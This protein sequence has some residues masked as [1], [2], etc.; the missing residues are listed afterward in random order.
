VFT[1]NPSSFVRPAPAV[2]LLSF[3]VLGAC[4]GGDAPPVTESP[5]G[6]PW[7]G[8][9]EPC[10]EK[11]DVASTGFGRCAAHFLPAESTVEAGGYGH[12]D[13]HALVS[14]PPLGST[15]VVSL[16]CGGSI[17]VDLGP[18][19]AVDGPG[20]DFV[21][22]EN[23]FSVEFPEVGHV[24]VSEDG[25]EWRKFPC[26]A[27]EALDGCAGRTPTSAVWA[28]D[29][30]DWEPLAA[31]GDPFDLA[32][33]GLE[34]A[35]FVRVVDESAAFWSGLDGDWCDPGMGGKGGFDLDAIAVVNEG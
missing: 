28:P 17:V 13:V 33:L 27:Q 18:E 2:C 5:P 24:W 22:F 12:D 16:G 8:C 1:L 11:D 30:A 15:H 26:A 29:V 14:G 23:P 10:V 3:L 31:G 25:C 20:A 34:R 7:T 6:D 32:D 19:G 4:E 21:V 35:R 9:V